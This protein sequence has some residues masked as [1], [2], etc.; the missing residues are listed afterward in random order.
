MDW[1]PIAKAYPMEYKKTQMAMGAIMGVV[2]HTTNHTA[3]VESIARFQQ[4]W[5]ASQA[6]SAHFVISRTGEIGQCRKLG[7]VAWHIG[8]NSP[9]YFGIEHIAKPGVA[10]TPQQ[11]E[12][13]GTLVS[14]L[15][16]MY[17]FPLMAFTSSGQRG[18]GMHVAFH[19]TGCGKSVFWRGT[20]KG[21]GQFDEVL[22]FAKSYSLLGY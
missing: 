1:L 13:S 2:L 18:V 5:N 20:T 15:S 4:N 10:I 8:K 9:N 17:N 22:A 21:G 19:A 12:A 14:W 3:G 16:G 7:E 6:Q 11:I